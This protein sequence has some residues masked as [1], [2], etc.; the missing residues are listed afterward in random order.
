VKDR[1]MVGATGE[2]KDRLEKLYAELET[3]LDKL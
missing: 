3:E 1:W 2:R